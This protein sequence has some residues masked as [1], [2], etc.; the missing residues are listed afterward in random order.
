M[1]LRLLPFAVPHTIAG[2]HQQLKTHQ[3]GALAARREF[4][5]RLK[6]GFMGQAVLRV[7]D[8]IYPRRGDHLP[9][10][11]KFPAGIEIH[12]LDQVAWGT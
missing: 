1:A 11:V 5:P 4:L 3:A 12:A 9:R 7:Q 2:S 10:L 6:R 8:L